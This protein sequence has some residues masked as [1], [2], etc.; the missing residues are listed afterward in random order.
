MIRMRIFVLAVSNRKA[1]M[2]FASTPLV[3]AVLTIMGVRIRVVV[4]IIV[5]QVILEIPMVTIMDL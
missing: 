3:R 1:T 5:I 2:T 4:V